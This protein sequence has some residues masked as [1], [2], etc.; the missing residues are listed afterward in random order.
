M[1][2]RPPRSTLSSSSAASDVYK[3]QVIKQ[4]VLVGGTEY[5][6]QELYGAQPD[7]TWD[8]G[9][10]SGSADC[11]I[12]MESC[13]ST[14]VLPCRH[15]CLCSTCSATFRLRNVQCPVCRQKVAALLQI[16][17]CNEGP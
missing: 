5:E 4:H 10:D 11:V 15:L 14:A 6:L 16:D 3:R 8:S 17:L 7:H 2:R 1:I 12:C 9:T 13:A